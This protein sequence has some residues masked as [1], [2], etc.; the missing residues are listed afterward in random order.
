MGIPALAV[1]PYITLVASLPALGDLFAAKQTP[2]SRLRLDQRLRGL[3]DPD[4]RLLA[5]ILDLLGWDR[6]R[7]QVSDAELV[8]RGEALMARLHC[9]TLRQ[10]VTHRLEMRTLLAALR[11]RQRGEAAPPPGAVRG[12]GRW[13]AT[14]RQNWQEPG[15][16]VARPFPWVLE[17]AEHLRN[18]DPVGLER[19]IMAEIWR[20]T[21]RFAVGHDFDFTAVV[22]YCLRFQL[23]ERRVAYDAEAATRRFVALVAASRGD[24]AIPTARVGQ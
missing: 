18:D 2:I 5:D 11:R 22:I 23:V 1:P 15:F 19:L 3:A 7:L 20:T 13:V 14:I 24:L 17:A 9:A 16:G 10:L 4:A 6:L 8:S 12:F 21:G